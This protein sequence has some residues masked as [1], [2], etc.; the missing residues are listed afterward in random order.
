MTTEEK[1]LITVEATVNAPVEK[2]WDFWT[3]PRHIIHWGKASED[4]HTSYAE[5]DL[6]PGGKFLSRMEA[7]DG[8][9]G[10]D[11]EG[12]YD[13][14]ET[15]KR[16]LYTMGDGRKVEVTFT[17]NGDQTKVVE[18]FEAEN[19]NSIEM[20]REGWQAIMDNFRKHA[21][22][23]PDLLHFEI[24]INANADKVYKALTD[25]KHYSEWTAPFNPS[26][27]YK[28][29]WEK[30][31]EIR[32]IGIDEN[33]DEGGMISRIKENIPNKF[34]SIEHL[35]MI[36]KGKEIT[37][38]PEVEGWAGA[39]ENYTFKEN[40]G[41]TTLLVDLDSNEQFKSYF[42]ETFP[43]ALNKLKEICETN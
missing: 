7:R 22:S 2:V 25:E 38:G 9:F 43:K 36:E 19:T 33:G 14:V 20:Q 3:D 17:A 24:F 1:T 29:S 13:V 6:R 35:G 42:E 16:I 5:N 40:N 18:T 28:G 11:F 15:H 34:I 4:W 21:E 30:G 12:V 31:S 26:S 23:S 10:F 27:H 37:S 8:S 32:F 41:K 39:L